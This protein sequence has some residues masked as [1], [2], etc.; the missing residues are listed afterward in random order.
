MHPA[1]VR[2]LEN[3]ARVFDHDSMW[4]ECDR[5]RFQEDGVVRPHRHEGEPG[6][7]FPAAD[8]LAWLRP[9]M[10]GVQVPRNEATGIAVTEGGT[11]GGMRAYRHTSPDP[12]PVMPRRR[13]A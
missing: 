12:L 13:S 4:P 7:T 11:K 2:W 6:D 8:F 9:E 5:F 10:T 3:A 1:T